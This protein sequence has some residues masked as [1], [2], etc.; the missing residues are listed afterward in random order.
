MKT[1]IAVPCFDM[2]HTDF[3]RCLIDLEKP[4]GTMYTVMRNTLIYNA[5]N[6]IAKNAIEQG[7]DRVLWLDSDIVFEPD[8]LIRL[9]E[10]LDNGLEYVSGLYFLRKIPTG[11]IIYS[12]VWYNVKDDVV[13]TG[14]HWMEEYPEGLFEIAASGFGCVMTSVE[15]LKKLQNKYGAPFTPMMGLGE[16]LA[17]CWRVKQAGIKMYC[18][19]TIK[20]GHIA[21]VIIDE[22]VFQK[23]QKESAEKNGV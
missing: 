14:A 22:S 12:D 9:S 23:Q 11:P 16:D 18:D 2:I 4:D 5:R 21:Q 8:T 10:H 1:L 3:M 7:F 15:L 19:S 20:C 6:F 17:F 13:N